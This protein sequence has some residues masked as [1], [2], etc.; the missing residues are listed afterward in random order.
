[1]CLSRSAHEEGKGMCVRQ[2]NKWF[3]RFPKGRAVR[4]EPD[5]FWKCPT[6]G[7]AGFRTKPSCQPGVGSLGSLALGNGIS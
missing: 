4:Q 6:A 5:A 3:S 1:M 7:D 2:Q